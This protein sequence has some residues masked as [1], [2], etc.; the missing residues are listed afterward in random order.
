MKTRR[1]KKTTSPPQILI[2]NADTA[3]W[4]VN[5]HPGWFAVISIRGH[6]T[7]GSWEDSPVDR[8]ASLCKGLLILKFDDIEKDEYNKFGE[9]L[10][11]V[12]PA[13]EHIKE[14]LDFA[15]GKDSLVVHCAAGISRS[16]AVAYVIAC[17]RMSPK[18]ALKVLDPNYHWPNLKVVQLGAELLGKPEMEKEILVW[19]EKALV[20][21]GL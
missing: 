12:C 19:R 14:A 17:S 7:F 21:L 15:R 13:K 9:R 20:S 10:P 2:R 8:V 18:E 16:S 6:K 11:Y 1:T 3:V 5:T 4:E